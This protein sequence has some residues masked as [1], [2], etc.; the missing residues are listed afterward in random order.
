M[1][2]ND[3]EIKNYIKENRDFLHTNGID[4]AH[5][6][7]CGDWFVY[8]YNKDFNYYEYYIRFSSLAELESII[9]E[10]LRFKTECKKGEDS[11]I[12]ACESSSIAK[13]VI[14]FQRYTRLTK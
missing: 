11:V 5:S 3:L 2:H 1:N 10:E 7:T 6:D 14:S 13:D 12:P 4:V 8:E 9:S